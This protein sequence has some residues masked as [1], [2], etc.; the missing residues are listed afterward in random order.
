MGSAP[1]FRIVQPGLPVFRTSCPVPK[2]GEDAL[3][4]PGPPSSPGHARRVRDGRVAGGGNAPGLMRAGCR[5]PLWT[6]RTLWRQTRPPGGTSAWFPSLRG[7]ACQSPW[8][9]PGR[10][11]AWAQM[12]PCP[13]PFLSSM[14]VRPRRRRRRCAAAGGAGTRAAQCGNV[15]LPRRPGRRHCA[16]GR[17]AQVC[18]HGGRG[19]WQ[20][21]SVLLSGQPEFVSVQNTGVNMAT[22]TVDASRA[23][24]TA[25][26]HTFTVIAAV[27]S[28]PVTRTV[29]VTVA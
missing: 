2:T 25:G 20:R 26:E 21:G 14:R 23:S 27:G 9:R 17:V 8:S 12:P 22:V 28:E 6:S 18:D 11:A 1:T 13:P 3:G 5:G 16:P 15:A 7:S 19:R 10:P 29:T 4:A 24:A